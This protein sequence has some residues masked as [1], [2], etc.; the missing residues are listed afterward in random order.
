MLA[1]E[2]TWRRREKI[3]TRGCLDRRPTVHGAA[4]PVEYSTE[5]AWANGNLGFFGA[6][7]DRVPRFQSI[8][9]FEWHGQDSAVP[10]PNHLRTDDL[11]ARCF[12]LTEAA[13]FAGWSFRLDDKASDI[14]DGATPT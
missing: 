14:C 4:K 13:D 11:T 6:C 8:D 12:N 10:E 1:V 3:I 5:Q 7:V 9:L 2:R